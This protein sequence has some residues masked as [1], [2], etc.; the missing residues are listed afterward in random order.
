MAD[1]VSS[2]T[3]TDRQLALGRMDKVGAFVTTT[4]TVLM[5]LLGSKCHPEYKSIEKKIREVPEEPT[6]L[7][8]SEKPGVPLPGPC[9]ASSDRHIFLG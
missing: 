9:R 4:E 2:R 3:Q 6:G 5:G 7:V 8:F 1:A